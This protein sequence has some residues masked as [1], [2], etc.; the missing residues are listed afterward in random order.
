MLKMDDEFAT[1]AIVALSSFNYY[2]E[3]PCRV[4]LMQALKSSCTV[5]FSLY[6]TIQLSILSF[7]GASFV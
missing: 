3:G 5:I 6:D 4:Y 7:L 1:S 2:F